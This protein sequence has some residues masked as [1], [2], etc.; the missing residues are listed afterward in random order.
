HL[1]GLIYLDP[2][3]FPFATGS[4]EFAE[5]AR[6]CLPKPKPGQIAHIRP[7]R[8]ICPILFSQFLPIREMR[9]IPEN[10][11]SANTREPAT[12]KIAELASISAGDFGTR[13]QGVRPEEYRKM[14]TLS[15]KLSANRRYFPP[16]PISRTRQR[17]GVPIYRDARR[18]KPA[19]FAAQK[20]G[21]PASVPAGDSG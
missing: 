15:D 3:G 6:L 9:T 21:P 4:T 1:N 13:N 12:K 19:G 10:L 17:S 2:V 7:I 20:T 16:R 5:V 11:R 8:P 14:R 18:R